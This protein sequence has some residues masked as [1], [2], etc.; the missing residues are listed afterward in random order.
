MKNVTN[1]LYGYLN[2]FHL[3]S[4]DE[5][6]KISP[7]FFI[8]NF[9]SRERLIHEDQQEEHVYYIVKGLV[10]K[11]FC[12]DREEYTTQFY[13]ETDIC[14]ASLSYFNGLPSVYVF[15]ALESTTCIG[16]KRADL[17]MLIS[18]IPAVAILFNK[19]LANLHWQKEVQNMHRITQSKRELF[20]DFC[21]KHPN[22]LHRIPQ[23]YLAS[24]LQ[25][26]PE[27]FCRMKHVL[28]N[29][30]KPSIDQHAMIDAA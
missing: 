5:Y 20:L 4:E 6:E 3:L 7:Y 15:E 9:R 11:Y 14:Y 8:N 25:I 28:Y 29:L 30:A 26:A 16:I 24:Y 22:W 17:E 27:T 23:K 1:L 21:K 18:E 12:K 2:Q 19:I 10:R 13:Q